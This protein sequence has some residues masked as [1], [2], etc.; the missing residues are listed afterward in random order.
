M[1]TTRLYY[2]VRASLLEG[3]APCSDEEFDRRCR[4][5]HYL[6]RRMERPTA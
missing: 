1:T 5:L 6:Q 3:I 4:V 2:R